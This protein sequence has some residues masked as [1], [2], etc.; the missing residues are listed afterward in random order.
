MYSKLGAD[1]R[2]YASNMWYK[3][4][5]FGEMIV[6]SFDCACGAL[7]IRSDVTCQSK[8]GSQ[9]VRDLRNSIEFSF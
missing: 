1:I 9:S 2:P 3:F 4:Y 5:D 7:L 6:I 8:N